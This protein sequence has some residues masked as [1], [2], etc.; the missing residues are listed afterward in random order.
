MLDSFPVG[1]V[2]PIRSL[3]Y[4]C[5]RN[6]NT[7]SWKLETQLMIGERNRLL[8][9]LLLLGRYD[10][11]ESLVERRGRRKRKGDDKTVKFEVQ[12]NNDNGMNFDEEVNYLTTSNFIIIISPCPSLFPPLPPPSLPPSLLYRF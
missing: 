10:V 12:A 11:Y 4:H 2:L 9:L 1:V 5:R 6:P 3:L 7:S 8:L